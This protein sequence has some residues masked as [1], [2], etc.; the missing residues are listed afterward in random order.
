MPEAAYALGCVICGPMS[1]E[2]GELAFF[3]N[4]RFCCEQ[5]TV[6]HT[7][8]RVGSSPCRRQGRRGPPWWLGLRVGRP[9]FS[10]PG[11]AQCIRP[12]LENAP[13]DRTCRPCLDCSSRA[14]TAS[15]SATAA[16]LSSAWECERESSRPC[17]S[18]T[19]QLLPCT[20]TSPAG[21]SVPAPG[22]SAR[23]QMLLGLFPWL[24]RAA[25]HGCSQG[26][27]VCLPSLWASL[28]ASL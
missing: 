3:L 13:R 2:T 23:A 9:G 27:R 10:A 26:S 28:W 14:H 21:Q 7:A 16:C 18:S 20:C 15:E 4:P 6:R 1:L 12:V 24:V 11:E 5:S 8:R 22:S 19:R 17:S 25:L